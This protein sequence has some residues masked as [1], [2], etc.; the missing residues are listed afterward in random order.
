MT[1]TIESVRELNAAELENVA[2]GLS[3]G[4]GLEIDAS[5]ELAAVSG[6]LD[7]VGGLVGDLLGT[8]TGA[9]PV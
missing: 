3:L 2:G 1:K 6:T 5:S 7:Q 9:L 4:L 8:V